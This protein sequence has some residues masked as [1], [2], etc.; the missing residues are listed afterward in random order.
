M[1]KRLYEAVGEVVDPITKLLTAAEE[2]NH[3]Q[4]K[5]TALGWEVE[6]IVTQSGAL[7]VSISSAGLSII[8]TDEAE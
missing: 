8:T 2:L 7:S 1:A 4:S 5:A 6:L 3:F